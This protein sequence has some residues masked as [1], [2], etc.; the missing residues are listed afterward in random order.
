MTSSPLPD[1]ST[2]FGERVRRRLTDDTTIWLTTVGRDGTPQPN[3]VGF[4]WDGADSVLIYSQSNA[5]R[6]ANIRRRPLVSLNFDSNGGNDIVVLT[7]T[8]EILDDHPPVTDNPAWL[9]KYGE[10]I[11][12]RFGS[13]AEFANRFSVPVRIHVTHTRGL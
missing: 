13:A 8:A 1:P 2:A 10:A 12:T 4:L 9:E 3:P 11:N 5:R 6:L 7:G